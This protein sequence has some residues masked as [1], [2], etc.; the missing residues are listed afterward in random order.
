MY[1][2][3]TVHYTVFTVYKTTDTVELL[4][5]LLNDELDP[6]DVLQA[7]QVYSYKNQIK[8]NTQIKQLICLLFTIYLKIFISE[9]YKK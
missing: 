2:H 6:V 9:V 1:N 7:Y 5:A 3:C 4:D 8:E